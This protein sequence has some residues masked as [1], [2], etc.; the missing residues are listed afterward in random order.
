MTRT[1]Q[2]FCDLGPHLGAVVRQLRTQA[3][4]SI[5][6][7]CR[8]VEKAGSTLH[9]P[10]VSWLERGMQAWSLDHLDVIAAALGIEP[11]VLVRMARVRRDREAAAGAGRTGG[12]V[13]GHNADRASAAG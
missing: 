9:H 4:L 13:L 2:S 5:R 3:G 11:D 6:D 12:E 1:P 10:T 8:S 7:V